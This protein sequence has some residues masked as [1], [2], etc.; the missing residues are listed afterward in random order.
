MVLPG[1]RG[2]TSAAVSVTL[3]PA[4]TGLG[5]AVKDPTCGPA[6]RKRAREKLSVVLLADVPATMI[7]PSGSTAKPSAFTGPEFEPAA[8]L[9]K[10]FTPNDVSRLPLLL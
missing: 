9:A 7:R 2:C 4:A 8:A 10:P 3:L 6:A 1:F 5:L